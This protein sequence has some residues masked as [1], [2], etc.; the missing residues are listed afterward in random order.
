MLL[1]RDFHPVAAEMRVNDDKLYFPK[2]AIP[3][4]TKSQLLPL[5]PRLGLASRR[6]SVLALHRAL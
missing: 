2:K 5:N 4:R 3:R 1:G 6:I